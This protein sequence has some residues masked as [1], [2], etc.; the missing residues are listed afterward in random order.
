MTAPQ[1]PFQL[2]AYALII[3]DFAGVFVV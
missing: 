3:N 2:E 1:K